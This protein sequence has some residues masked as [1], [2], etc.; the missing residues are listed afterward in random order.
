MEWQEFEDEIKKRTEQRL[1]AN[2]SALESERVSLSGIVEWD[3]IIDE[4]EQSFVI[5][6]QASQ[7]MCS[8]DSREL[9]ERN[10]SENEASF[11]SCVD[12]ISESIANHEPFL[13]Q[14]SCLHNKIC[15]NNA[16]ESGDVTPGIENEHA[17][18]TPSISHQLNFPTSQN[19]MEQTSSIVNDSHKQVADPNCEPTLMSRDGSA[20]EFDKQDCPQISS[21]VGVSL[22]RQM[23][24]VSD[25][26][27][28]LA[29]ANVLKT[30]PVSTEDTVCSANDGRKQDKLY[31]GEDV[32][33]QTSPEC[34]YL[35][36]TAGNEPLP[37]EPIGDTKSG[38][39][40]SLTLATQ[41]N[42]RY[43]SFDV[44]DANKEKSYIKTMG[45]GES[46]QTL[47]EGNE[48]AILHPNQESL[49]SEDPLPDTDKSC[50]SPQKHS[51]SGLLSK[52][53]TDNHL[54]DS[55]KSDL[56]IP[57]ADCSSTHDAS[58]NAQVKTYCTKAIALLRSA[59]IS[60]R[61]DVKQVMSRKKLSM[62]KTKERRTNSIQNI[63]MSH[64]FNFYYYYFYFF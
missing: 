49:R 48:M 38:R 31:H 41:K 17:C 56:E 28:D 4:V 54:D 61:F 55:H 57:A 8:S 7:T 32:S 3:D 5:E 60:S 45:H 19:D 58:N 59:L 25:N 20:V 33:P 13:E 51:P 42:N 43:E 30:T 2:E 14:T 40:L 22:S 46:L 18:I 39:N 52:E 16:M 36:Q 35:P 10:S 6:F 21:E 9:I 63:D 24:D 1:M 27:L 53:M 50:L 12:V 15:T 47:R 34:E 29:I 26:E 44:P 64:T 11:F 37:C 23:Q 62:S